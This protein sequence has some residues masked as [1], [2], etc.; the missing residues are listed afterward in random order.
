V[1]DVQRRL[2]GPVEVLQDDHGRTANGAPQRSEHLAGGGAPL[3]HLRQLAA[4][5]GGDVD[6]GAE[7]TR[8]EQRLAGAGQHRGR[9]LP[10]TE[11]AH[12]RRLAHP[13]LAAQHDHLAAPAA[14]HRRKPVVELGEV[15][16]ALQQLHDATLRPRPPADQPT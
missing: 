1:H 7:R 13:R 14:T 2:I 10:L 8:R 12:E 16:V 11:G 3:G 6:Q 9:S 5:L 4:D 15:A